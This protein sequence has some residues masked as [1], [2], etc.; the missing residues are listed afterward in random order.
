VPKQA[1]RG[2]IL[3]PTVG[4]SDAWHNVGLRPLET[5][6]EKVFESRMTS[7]E[8]GEQIVVFVGILTRS[9]I[10]EK[11]LLGIDP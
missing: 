4:D 11:H 1:D 5:P 3:H 8:Q 10:G 6:L 2:P 9:K 7:T